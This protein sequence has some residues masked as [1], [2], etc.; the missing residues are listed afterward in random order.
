[1]AAATF[2]PFAQLN[3]HEG[4]QDDPGIASHAL[5]H[6][7]DLALASNQGPEVLDRLDIA[8]LGNRGPRYAI[9][10]F[11]GR[12]GNEMNVD[13]LH[14][15]LRLRREKSPI[16]RITRLFQR[17]RKIDPRSPDNHTKRFPH[18]DIQLQA[19]GNTRTTENCHGI[20][21]I[22]PGFGYAAEDPRKPPYDSRLT[23]VIHRHIARLGA[24][25]KIPDYLLDESTSP[26]LHPPTY[27]S[28]LLMTK[29]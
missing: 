16:E 23:P 28:Y 26:L 14:M 2:K 25:H 10:R 11:A 22:I 20:L 5:Q 19:H 8:E 3:I 4:E 17:Q 27:C 24:V 29:K 6:I 21:L 15:V 18:G 12:V 7:V 13:S 9:D 1:M